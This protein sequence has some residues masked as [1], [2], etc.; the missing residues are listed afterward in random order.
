MAL[1]T[2]SFTFN[3]AHSVAVQNDTRQFSLIQQFARRVEMNY[4]G[5][6]ITIFD[7]DAEGD[8]VGTE[9]GEKPVAEQT[10]SATSVALREWARIVPVSNRVVD[11][12]P[13]GVMQ[14]IQKSA[15]ASLARAFDTLAFTGVGALA[16][17]AADSLASVTKTTA[18][19]TASGV[20]TSGTWT[21]LNNGLGLLANDNKEWSGSLWDNRVE[22][23]FNNDVDGNGRPLYLDAPLT[24]T[25][26]QGNRP[27]RVLGRPADFARNVNGKQGALVT[28]DVVGYAGDW[29]RAVW[30]M[31]GDIKYQVSTE[32]SWVQGGVSRSAFQHNVTLFRVEALLGF[33]VL[34]PDAFVKFTLGTSV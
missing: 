12:N 4:G 13:D 25:S 1:I 14:I 33:K 6:H 11:A 10:V 8:W 24:G 22:V 15:Y 31:V 19:Q 3:P 5:A 18:L 7:T 2:G 21:G 29:D 30:G 16:G 23:V 34:D 27:G 32:A 28:A 17:S 20:G 9:T 26:F